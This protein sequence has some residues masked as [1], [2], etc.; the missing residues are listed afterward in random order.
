MISSLVGDGVTRLFNSGQF[1]E[2]HFSD[3]FITR[4]SSVTRLLFTRSLSHI[5]RGL[6]ATVLRSSIMN[7]SLVTHHSSLVSDEV[8]KPRP[9]QNL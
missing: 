7:S 1:I 8:T 5:A 4:R 3:E 9:L 6:S 2:H